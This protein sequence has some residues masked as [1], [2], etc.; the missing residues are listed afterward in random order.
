[1]ATRFRKRVSSERVYNST[2]NSKQIHFTPR[3]QSILSKK[4][5]LP[6]SR[7]RQQTLTQIDFVARYVPA[8]EDVDLN[9]I[10]EEEPRKRKRRR[11]LAADGITTTVETRASRRRKVK[12][13]VDDEKSGS[14]SAIG[15][16][17]H[18]TQTPSSPGRGNL[19]PPVTPVTV[20]KVEI[21]SSQSPADTPPSTRST[22]SVRI[23]LRSP[24]KALSTNVRIP[25]VFSPKARKSVDWH[26]KLEVKSSVSWENEDSQVST[27]FPSQG[28]ASRTGD[29]VDT[30]YDSHGGEGQEGGH[31]DT[32]ADLQQSTSANENIENLNK[33]PLPIDQPPAQRSGKIEIRDS[34]DED[35]EEDLDD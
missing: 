1:M 34:D 19:R 26:P 15:D 11:T 12:Q 7:T 16:Q 6:S 8:D 3:N 13:E 30:A 9:Y 32:H 23:P 28:K 18:I 29:D 10:Q 22:G 33:N 24:L 14:A 20:G 27:I 25:L 4:P 5:A 31:E 35:E 21:P 2:P 17:A